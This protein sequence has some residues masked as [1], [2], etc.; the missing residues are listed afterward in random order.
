MVS[1]AT[2]APCASPTWPSWS[3][4]SRRSSPIPAACSCKRSITRCGST[5]STR[6]MSRWT[7]TSTAQPY[8]LAPGQEE[9]P[10]VG[11]VHHVADLGPF[12]LL[13]GVASCDTAGRELTLAVV[14][15][16]RDQAQRAVV[17]LVGASVR[18]GAALAEVNGPDVAARNSF[19]DPRCVDVSERKLAAQGSRFELEFPAHS[20]TVVRASLA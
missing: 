12:G 15:R 17:E 7:S 3:T 14:N 8:E 10:S 5:P 6:G 9:R 1:S 4:P 19:E 13:D 11:R 18:G 20:V 16:D 2:A